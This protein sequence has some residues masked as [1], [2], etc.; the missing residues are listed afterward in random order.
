LESRGFKYTVSPELEEMLGH[1]DYE[2]A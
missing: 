1:F 2:G